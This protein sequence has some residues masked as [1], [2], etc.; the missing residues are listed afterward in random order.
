MKGELA[1]RQQ[2]RLEP[3]D[4][5][6]R[7]EWSRPM[8]AIWRVLERME[9]ALFYRPIKALGPSGSRRHRPQDSARAVALR[10]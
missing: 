10:A 6:S 9:L 1:E 8:R 5:D 2:L 4:L 3:V 7:I